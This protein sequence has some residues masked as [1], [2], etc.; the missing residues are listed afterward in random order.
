MREIDTRHSH[1][2]GRLRA[3]LL[4]VPIAALAVVLGLALE[5]CGGSVQTTTSTAVTLPTATTSGGLPGGMT[6]AS[7]TAPAGGDTT[8]S[9][10][11]APGQDTTTTALAGTGDSTTT[12]EKLSTAEQQLADGRI[13]AMGYIKKVGV[14]DGK[15][16]ISI[17]YAEMLAGQAAVSA[18]AADGVSLDTDYYIKNTNTE[19]RQFEVSASVAITTSSWQGK[20]NNPVTWDV[21]TSFWSATPPDPEAG[22]LRDNPWW[23]ERDGQTVVKIDE[24]YLP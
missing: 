9:V 4:S 20:L 17:D 7:T 14:Q 2:R 13:K 21:F 19:K 15:R 23:I 18:A 8:S 6:T 5:G 16:Y 24:Q 3:L 22:M 11:P 10:S 1:P 12:T